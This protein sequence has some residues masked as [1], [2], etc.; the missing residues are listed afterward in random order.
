MDLKLYMDKLI[1][2]T[3]AAEMIGV[4][5]DTLR[6]WDES[7]KL[8]AIR[9]GKGSHRL[10]RLKDI[11]IFMTD[12]FTLAKKWVMSPLPQEP[13]KMFYCPNS[14]VFQVRL[15]R[16]DSE[17]KE[18]EPGLF[19]LVSSTAGEIGNN[20]FD[21]NLGKWPDVNGI[22][23]AYDLAKKIV[24]LADRGLGIL[25]TLGRVRPEL[26]THTEAL[27]VAFTEVVTGR[28]PEH[29]GN[30]LKYVRR[31]IAAFPIRLTFQT[32]DAKLNLDQGDTDIIIEQS[33]ETF[34]GCL[35][36]IRF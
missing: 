28:A 20:S 36:L 32:G 34:R 1:N 7:G 23:F 19:S 24:V 8:I 22:F 30:G 12:L 14:S 4:S 9:P 6:R 27:K 13:E 16:M 2:I 3:K 26:K 29:R 25:Q 10:Y 5:I 21:H 11:E 31:V 18:I 33:N 17:L 35:A 15:N